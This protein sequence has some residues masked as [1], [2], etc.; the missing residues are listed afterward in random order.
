M[1]SRTK[2]AW[3]YVVLLALVA[4]VSL[5]IAA[6]ATD[7]QTRGGYL[8]ETL[9]QIQSAERNGTD[10]SITS[11]VCIS[12][13]TMWLTY[14]GAC[15]ARDTKFKFHCYS[16][17]GECSAKWDTFAAQQLATVSP[18]LG[19]WFSSR[20]AGSQRLRTIKGA[21]LIDKF[22]VRECV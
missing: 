12:S 9:R 7:I 18:D 14:Q 11:R 15:I 8:S 20:V 22:N 17:N 3:V 21:E 2:A 1:T 5:A 16:K 6:F 4:Y 10:V 13:C 19:D